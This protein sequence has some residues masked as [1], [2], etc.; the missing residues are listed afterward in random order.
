MRVLSPEIPAQIEH[1][2]Q[3]FGASSVFHLWP[4]SFGG[5]RT[6]RCVIRG[7][8]VSPNK[9][10]EIFPKRPFLSPAFRPVFQ[11]GI[12]WPAG[13]GQLVTGC[14]QTTANAKTDA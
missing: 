11:L 7:Q 2:Y 13:N 14:L 9:F 4:F 3:N 1:R 10:R 8:T 12:G 5:G 6:P